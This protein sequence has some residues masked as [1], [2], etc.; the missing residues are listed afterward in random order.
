VDGH[1]VLPRE[2]KDFWKA[3]PMKGNQ[4]WPILWLQLDFTMKAQ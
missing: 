2:R 3:L 4:Y 1:K